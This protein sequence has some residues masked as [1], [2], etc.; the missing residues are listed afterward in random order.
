MVEETRT[1][2]DVAE[3]E[4]LPAPEM[5]LDE[6]AATISHADAEELEATAPL[7]AAAP[8]PVEPADEITD[9][10]QAPAFEDMLANFER[11]NLPVIEEVH[12]EQWMAEPLDAVHDDDVAADAFEDEAD[13]LDIDL[14]I[15]LD[16]VL[17]AEKRPQQSGTRA[18][19]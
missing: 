11:A 14:S 13:D 10:E 12:A 7:A 6:F 18:G 1:A 9:I 8:E 4:D 17:H 19:H 15:E 5:A 2:A 3:T 16:A